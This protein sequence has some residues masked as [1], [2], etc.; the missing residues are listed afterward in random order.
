MSCVLRMHLICQMT[1]GG[2]IADT[3]PP[4]WFCDE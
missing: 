2:D 1:E 4:P 3:M